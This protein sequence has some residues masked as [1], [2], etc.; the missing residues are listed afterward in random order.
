MN[1]NCSYFCKFQKDGKCSLENLE[2]EKITYKINDFL[3][4][5]LNFKKNLQANDVDYL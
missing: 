2:T 1:I 3:C 5:Y 4:P